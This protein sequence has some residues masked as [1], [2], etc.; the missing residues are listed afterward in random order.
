VHAEYID[1][2]CFDCG[3]YAFTVSSAH[4]WCIRWHAASEVWCSAAVWCLPWRS[5]NDMCVRLYAVQ[6]MQPCMACHFTADVIFKRDCFY[7]YTSALFHQ[8]M[9]LSAVRY[10]QVRSRAMCNGCLMHNQAVPSCPAPRPSPSHLE[11]V[12]LNL[13]INDSSIAILVTQVKLDIARHVRFAGLLM[14]VL[15]TVQSRA[16]D[17]FLLSRSPSTSPCCQ[18]VCLKCALKA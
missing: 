18:T 5:N 15:R 16:H 7:M 2:G 17:T 1:H 3:C 11:P 14:C 10:R 8:L 12:D 13:V 4:A 9:S 6:C